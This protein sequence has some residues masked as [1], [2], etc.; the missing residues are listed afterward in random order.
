MKITS[1]HHAHALYTQQAQVRSAHTLAAYLRGITLFLTYLD[2]KES[3]RLPF[4]QQAAIPSQSPLQL[5]I[6]SDEA[7]LSHFRGWLMQQGYSSATVEL[8]LAGIIHWFQFIQTHAAFPAEFSATRAVAAL[9][10]PLAADPSVSPAPKTAKAVTFEYDLTGLLSYYST[11]QASRTVQK[12][13]E[14]FRRWELTRL[15]N[16][17][18]VQLLAETGG[19]VSA[20]LNLN[21]GEIQGFQAPLALRLGGKNE[22]PYSIDL[23]DSLPALQAYLTLRAVPVA[24]SQSAPLFVSHAKQHEGQ[25]MS[26]VIAWRVI[27]HAAKALNLPP[28]SPH[29]LRHWRA[30]QLILAGHQPE[31]VQRRLGHR[32]LQTI[33]AY[34]GHW[35][36]DTPE[37]E[38]I[39]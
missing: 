32:T 34:Y 37:D 13:P 38:P 22:H 30:K 31:E 9:K 14:Q 7:L 1:F 3:A 10:I 20:A 39:P 35:Y 4:Q 16:A 19:Q 24:Q 33:Y 11:Q 28:I 26:R 15:R 8:R 17:A 23:R 2:A 6:E 21:V 18:L 36:A 5:L 25:R 12:K 29:D 27:Q